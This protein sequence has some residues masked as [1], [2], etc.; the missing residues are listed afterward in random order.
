VF[1]NLPR[2]ERY[3]QIF[4]NFTFVVLRWQC[5]TGRANHRSISF[6]TLWL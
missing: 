2:P 4:L 5:W 1:I 6:F 3:C